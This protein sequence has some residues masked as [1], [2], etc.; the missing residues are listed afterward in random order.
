MPFAPC[1]SVADTAASIAFY[2]KLGFDVDSSTSRP[3][4][5][6]HM[7]L[8]QGEFCAMLYRNDDLK[9][10]LPVLADQPI[11]FA[12]MLYLAVDDLD[13]FYQHASQHATVVKEMTTDHNNQREFYIQDPDGYVIGFNDK[14]ALQ[15][16]GLGQYA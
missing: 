15:A 9:Q 11:G 1:M 4:D 7:L 2:K 14:A 6:I 3:G 16:S 13:G 5:D 10:W 12:G 8:Y